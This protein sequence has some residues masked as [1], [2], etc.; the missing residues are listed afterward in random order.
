MTSSPL[1]VLLGLPQM[2]DA[3]AAAGHEVATGAPVDIA[4]RVRM[5]GDR[6]VVILV[7]GSTPGASPWAT[8]QALAGRQVAW[9]ETD[10]A[11][12][13]P[14][15]CLA[16]HPPFRTEDILEALGLSAPPGVA[17][18]WPLNAGRL[19]SSPP[20]GPTV[21]EPV[22]EMARLWDQAPL[23]REEPLD[24]LWGRDAPSE[25][26]PVVQGPEGAPR[27]FLWGQGPTPR[28][29]PAQASG[30]SPGVPLGALWGPEAPGPAHPAQPPN[31]DDLDLLWQVESRRRTTPAPL[32]VFTSAA[33][34][35]GVSSLALALAQRAGEKLERVLVV[36]A[37]GDDDLQRLLWVPAGGL[38]CFTDY[39]LQGKASAAVAVPSALATKRPAGLPLPLFGAV[40]GRA[41][42]DCTPLVTELT[43]V[44]DLVVVDAGRADR[45]PAGLPGL[46]ALPGALGIGVADDGRTSFPRLLEWWSVNSLALAGSRW[47][48]ALNRVASPPSFDLD[49]VRRS[50]AG[51]GASVAG[52]AAEDQGT[53]RA[54]NMGGFPESSDWTGL[55]DRVLEHLL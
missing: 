26:G 9:L 52:Q 7:N 47:V 44:A 16:V 11:P 5:A 48:V 27:H 35:A 13:A 10:G 30:A 53:R 25:P 23:T 54:L 1:L 45:A 41:T 34:G 49:Q 24:V 55:L 12:P 43:F 40:L 3:L 20:S 19:A 31:P 37:S 21:P 18:S 22:P 17:E 38:P 46:L 2:A 50:A 32:A 51:F 33:G 8:T 15:G 42:K 14:A 4:D 28:L 39:I 6:P 36:D 29:T